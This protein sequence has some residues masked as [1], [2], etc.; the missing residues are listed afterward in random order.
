MSNYILL[1]L[2]KKKFQVCNVILR[3]LCLSFTFFYSAGIQ[4]Y[5]TS[6]YLLL[7]FGDAGVDLLGFLLGLRR[8]VLA[9]GPGRLQLLEQSLI[10]ELEPMDI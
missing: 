2:H 9:A 6:H 4:V 1:K 7:E 5:R 8:H 3:Y 10:L